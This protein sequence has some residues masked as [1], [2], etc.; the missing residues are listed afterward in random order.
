M[1]CAIPTYVCICIYNNNIPH[2]VHAKRQSEQMIR[3]ITVKLL[4]LADK[5]WLLCDPVYADGLV[6]VDEI[7]HLGSLGR[8]RRII[9]I[10][11][12]QKIL[13]WGLLVV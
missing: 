8:L 2:S 6:D 9:P 12:L 13:V 3:Y 10:V 4:F 1:F 5:L 7:E 11:V